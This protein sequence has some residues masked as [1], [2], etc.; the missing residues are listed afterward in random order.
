MVST[1]RRFHCTLL[2]R[3]VTCVYAMLAM[4][5]QNTWS[6]P[7]TA[8]MSRSYNAGLKHAKGLV[9]S[10][11]HP[12]LGTVERQGFIYWGVRGGEASPPNPPTS[13]PKV[14]T[15]NAISNNKKL[16]LYVFSCIGDWYSKMGSKLC[17]LHTQLI[18]AHNLPPKQMKP[19]KGLQYPQKFFQEWEQT[20][21]VSMIRRA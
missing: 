20:E 4:Y 12:S 15:M 8:D 6:W 2:R 3:F 11:S 16:W 21:Q 17:M 13:S 18:F 7:A 5:M 19:W 1:I 10:A 14:L 9:V